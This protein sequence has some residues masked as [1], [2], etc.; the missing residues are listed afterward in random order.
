LIADCG[1]GYN[2]G[3]PT[4]IR[5]LLHSII[6]NSGPKGKLGNPSGCVSF[7]GRVIARSGL[8]DEAIPS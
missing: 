1:L 7:S 5:N 3:D 2:S 4:P 6:L 8:C